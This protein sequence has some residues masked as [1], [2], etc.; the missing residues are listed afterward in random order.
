MPRKKLPAA[1]GEAF[2]IVGVG[3]SAG[4]LEAYRRLLQALPV[5][6]GMAFVLVQHLDPKHESLLSKLLSRATK[7]PVSEVTHGIRIE[8]NH[9]YVIPPDSAMGIRDGSLQLLARGRLNPKPMPVDYFL[10]SLA[11]T[12][13]S[14]AIG[15]ILSGVA[16][17]G[18]LGLAAIKA[19][20]GITFAQDE[21]A[22]YDGM[23]RSA[24][25]SGCVDFVFSPEGI[26][27]ELKKIS[28]HRYLDKPEQ[29]SSGN[30]G[31]VLRKTIAL[32]RT[33]CGIDFTHYKR[34]TI[35]RRIARRMLLHKISTPRQYL[36][37]LYGNR[38]EV[39]ALCDD[40]LIHVTEFFRDPDAFRAL[41]KTVL[42]KLFR[43]KERPEPLRIW[44]AGCSTGEEAYSVAI[45]VA[46][47]LSEAQKAA[48]VQIFATDVSDTALEKARA[49]IYSESM[50][51][52]ISPARM[53]RFFV[54]C[55]GGYQIAKTVREMCIFARQDL[56]KDSP[57]SRL[58]L[59]MCR[60]VLIYMEPV[61][62]KRVM[63]I[64]HYALKPNGFLVLGKS[65][66]IS[67]FS[68]FFT[69]V[70]RKRKIYARNASG[71]QPR[72]DV[73]K[74]P[75]PGAAGES[76][77]KSEE[78]GR[79]DV[80]READRIVM[81]RYAPP[82][83]VVSGDSHIL[84]FRGNVAPYLS[85]S[86]GQASLSLFKMVRPEFAVDLRT[87]IHRSGKQ[88]APVRKEGLT[89]KRNGRL[90]QVSLEV[91]PFQGPAGENFF[92][93][94]FQERRMAD[95]AEAGNISKA[96]S[97]RNEM[98]VA[99]LRREL[100][101]TKEHVQSII[102]E[103]ESTNEELKSANEEA[104]SSN[105]ELQSTNEE[106][107]TAQEEL[108]SSNEEL[109]TIN[110]QLQKRN[111]ELNQLTDDWSNLLGGLNIPV[112]M[113]G[114]NNRIRRFTAPA[115]KLLN[116]LPTDVGRP[117]GNIRPNA[118]IP[119]LEELLREVTS[120]ATQLDLEIQD[121]D[122]RWYSLRVRPYRTADEQIDGALM[123]FID[124]HV[125]KI[126]QEALQAQNSFSAA[127]MESS[128]ALVM[129]TDADGRVTA[130]NQAC[131]MVSGYS[132][133]VMAG[134]VL[135]ESAL[136]PKA[137]I[138]GERDIYRRLLRGGSSIQHESHWIAKNGAQRL[139]SW[140]SAAIS[141]AAGQPRH[142]VRIGTDITDRRE[143]ENALKASE[144][145]LRDGQTQL[146]A[147]AAGLLAAQEEERA[148]V[149]R[150]LHDDISQKLAALSLAAESVLRKDPEREGQLRSELTRLSHR[151]RGILRD[152]EQTAYELHP[153]SLDHLGLAVALKA[154]C[155]DFSRQDGIAT[156]FTARNLPRAISAPLGLTVYRV[157]QEAL[158]NIAKHAG[159]K[160]A[161]VSLS[162]RPGAILLM[163]KDFGRGFD[164]SRLPP[165][166]LGLISMEERVR[167]S[168]GTFAIKASAGGVR[169][170]IRIPLATP[171]PRAKG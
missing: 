135:W 110:E 165:R 159:T 61:L 150:D 106:L 120:K 11:A 96:R 1:S 155:A 57:Y 160:K 55:D 26:A 151:L 20:G 76:S 38:A 134:K 161:I 82:G 19:A 32:L 79:F 77:V 87:A 102:E 97:S 37:H 133:E 80:Q 101:S 91:T 126:T 148:R 95:A 46:E 109:I 117:I 88:Q 139:I 72:F 24:I 64:F 78:A 140:N 143:I 121:R 6:T 3:A 145:A 171:N 83:L 123:I 164:A 34:S 30:G 154:Y 138:A 112:V 56:A 85:P 99:R 66:S 15:V 114:R 47:Y 116:L 7:M 124:I 63:N 94:L 2:P 156:R 125:L 81:Q 111:Q 98:E 89:V 22:E 45:T 93:V 43:N 69:P 146:Q 163:I 68:D 170:D 105:E 162:G 36:K 9:V 65:E 70:G 50:M 128:G 149:A 153:S 28:L 144:T 100:Q 103:H 141:S 129:V 84:H 42:P 147:L 166:G 92:L 137:E 8:P 58:D 104:L 33:A 12:Q 23:P 31:E 130:F 86:P 52:G 44:V 49:G 107:E 157:V 41:K 168:G 119:D 71:Q 118:K 90:N 108:Q 13:G 39:T 5:N 62:Q 25:A 17:D 74:S 136:I 60:N 158:R 75:A 122:G 29:P 14:R 51:S 16:N 48:Q 53:R 152:V 113:L 67:G 59:V 54:R 27:R 18:T 142:L 4:G 167:Q 73:P 127:V 21:T 131:Q 10:Q 115:E 169:I 132:L 40:I 35:D